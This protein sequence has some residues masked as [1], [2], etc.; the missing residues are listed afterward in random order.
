[1]QGIGDDGFVVKHVNLCF[2]ELNKIV[3]AYIVVYSVSL[4]RPHTR[5]ETAQ[6]TLLLCATI[7]L[8]KHYRNNHNSHL[9][10]HCAAGNKATV[11]TCNDAYF[12]RFSCSFT[13]LS[14]AYL[15]TKSFPVHFSF[16]FLNIEVE[17][18][19]YDTTDTG[20]G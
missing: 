11:E 4:S 12:N 13:L 15:H 5:W 16:L 1:M 17:D 19:G 20:G 3:T 7:T 8:S 14:E 10:K 18:R 6:L 9:H 2:K